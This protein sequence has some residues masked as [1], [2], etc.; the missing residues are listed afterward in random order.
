MSS[1]M[2]SRGLHL[3]ALDILTD[4]IGRLPEGEDRQW[5]QLAVAEATL[6][7]GWRDRVPALLDAIELDAE[8]APELHAKLALTR[9]TWLLNGGRFAEAEAAWAAQRHWFALTDDEVLAM[10]VAMFDARIATQ[11]G[12]LAAAI[13]LIEPLVGRL[14]QRRASTKRVQFV[15][16][17]AALYDNLGR[18]DESLA[19]HHEALNTARSLGSR[20]LVAEASIN[21][22]YCMSD[23][24][25]HEEAIEFGEAALKETTFDNE[26]IVRVNLAANY[27]YAGRWAEAIEHY[28]VLAGQDLPHLRVVAL[29]RWSESAARLGD[30]GE[31]HSL[32]VRVLESLPDTDFPIAHGTAAVVLHAYGTAEQVA[33][34]HRLVPDFDP[35]LLPPFLRSELTMAMERASSDETV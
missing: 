16:S 25:R 29:A 18:H 4:A 20:Y 13:D 10:D 19:L 35:E 23:L 12:E 22:L 17:L 34:F 21:M 24:G 6:E 1:Q 31:S 11:R 7:G 27:R 2:R 3:A 28:R 8:A 26:P 30:L 14:R 15:T 5:L 32:N 33:S 9:S